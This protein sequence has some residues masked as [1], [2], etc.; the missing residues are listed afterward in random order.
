MSPFY[1]LRGICTLS[2]CLTVWFWLLY[3]A[4]LSAMWRL[5]L[6][7]RIRHN[8]AVSLPLLAVIWLTTQRHTLTIIVAFNEIVNVAET[9]AVVHAL[10]YRGL[11][12][13]EAAASVPER[14]RRVVRS[15]ASGPIPRP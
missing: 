7:L 9:G 6:H 8:P 2:D 14:F 4:A 3:S 10:D 1:N 5:C 12:V 11:A 13:S 15:Q